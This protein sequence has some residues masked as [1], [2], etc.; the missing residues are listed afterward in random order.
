MNNIKFTLEDFFNQA[1]NLPNSVPCFYIV[2]DGDIVLYVGETTNIISRLANHISIA[3]LFAN[4]SPSLLGKIIRRNYPKSLKWLIEFRPCDLSE[5]DRKKVEKT[6]IKQLKPCLN[7]LN[8]KYNAT[9]HFPKY[10]SNGFHKTLLQGW[11]DDIALDTAIIT[12]YKDYWYILRN[13][14]PDERI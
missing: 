6:L 12:I 3:T 9:Y 4:R 8:K 5:V 14:F 10:Q 11:Q 7:R 13:L 2:R 1:T